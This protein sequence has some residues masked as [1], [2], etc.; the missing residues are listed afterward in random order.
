VDDTA[1]AA[2][3]AEAGR[4]CGGEELAERLAVEDVLRL[5]GERGGRAGL[6]EVVAEIGDVELAARTV[7]RLAAEGLVE[8]RGSVVALTELGARRARGLL[9][10]HRRAEELAA[11]S[12]RGVEPHLLAHCLEHFP[13]AVGVFERLAG[14][15]PVRLVELPRGASGYVVAVER[16]SPRLLARLIGAGLVPGR[17]V[18]VF[19]RAPAVVL[20]L[21]G[22]AG[23]LVALGR[24]VAEAVLVVPAS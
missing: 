2:G 20:V 12:I 6:R 5:L 17:R 11:A 1:G 4:G 23:R 8:R 3:G 16:P 19:A 21:V 13:E 9:E 22:S 10:A 15:R 14:G 18:R 24:R 7:E